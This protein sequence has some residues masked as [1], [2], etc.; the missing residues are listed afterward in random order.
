MAVDNKYGQV[1]LEFGTIGES[2]PVVVFR[3]QDRL[4]PDL[5]GIYR[6]LCLLAGSPQHHLDLIAD[7][8]REIRQW[9]AEHGAR[10]PNSDAYIARTGGGSG[11]R[12]NPVYTWQ[13]GDPLYPNQPGQ[14]ACPDCG[15]Q[16]MWGP[17]MGNAMP[18]PY[19]P[20]PRMIPVV[21][22]PDARS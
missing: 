17:D 15:T 21:E 7:R 2:E 10:T 20:N 1:V 3:G 8:A 11:G 13:P 6:V 16:V 14:L 19:C 18:C 22:A 9:Q 5:L 12:R 4:L